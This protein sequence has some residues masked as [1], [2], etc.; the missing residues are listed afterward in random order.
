MFLFEVSK[1]VFSFSSFYSSLGDA[2]PAF[3]SHGGPGERGVSSASSSSQV[4]DRDSPVAGRDSQCPSI[5]PSPYRKTED[6]SSYLERSPSSFSFSK[7]T[8]SSSSSSSCLFSQLY[9]SR[10]SVLDDISH[11]L[12]PP[13]STC[14]SSL[15]LSPNDEHHRQHHHH[16]P[17]HPSRS[18]SSLQRK[19]EKDICCAPLSWREEEDAEVQIQLQWY[20]LTTYFSSR[21]SSFTSF[22]HSA[23]E[24][25]R[26]DDSISSPSEEIREGYLACLVCRNLSFFKVSLLRES[27]GKTKEGDRNTGTTTTTTATTSTTTAPQPSSSSPSSS[28]I[29]SRVGGK[30]DGEEQGGRGDEEEEGGEKK[31]LPPLDFL[32][33][34]DRCSYQHRG[35]GV[36]TPEASQMHSRSSLEAHPKTFMPRDFL[37]Q[38][39]PHSS[40]SS[41][42]SIGLREKYGEKLLQI[43]LPLEKDVLNSLLETVFGSHQTRAISTEGIKRW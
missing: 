1:S 21:S 6:T 16:H 24:K 36:H 30:I 12:L 13:S 9:P 29:P 28:T 31:A 42:S 38:D 25:C 39:L 5:H 22:F 23:K 4:G 15:S 19:S 43:F 40:S 35:G 10:S 11:L 26:S 3:S 20:Y 7:S 8:S 32:Y 34:C 2:G 14:C 37:P 41:L 27:Q 18:P 33:L 17:H